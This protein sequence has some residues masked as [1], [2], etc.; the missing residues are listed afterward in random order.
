MVTIESTPE[1]AA[2]VYTTHGAQSRDRAPPTGATAHA[3]R[4][5]AARASRRP[6]AQELEP[7]ASYPPLRPDR[8]VFQDVL[9]QTAMLQF[10]Q[11]RREHGRGADHDPL[12]PP[13]PGAASTA[14]RTCARRSPKTTRSTTSCARRRRSTAPASGARAPA[15]STRS[16]SRTTPSPA[17]SSSAPTRTRRTPAAS[18]PARSASA[19]PTRS[20]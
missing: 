16:C 12:R 1:M 17:R 5:G 15:S 8:V 19:A 10:M 20:R 18:A 2:R 4:Q 3:R 6:G 11:T 7:G 9:G 13:D 14:R